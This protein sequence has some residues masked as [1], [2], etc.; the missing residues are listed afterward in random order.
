M[1]SKLS[2]MFGVFAIGMSVAAYAAEETYRGATVGYT[3]EGHPYIGN[4]DASVT[5]SEFSDYLCPFCERH[6]RQTLPELIEKYAVP[7]KVRFVF[8]D[9]PIPSLHPQAPAAAE[10]ALCVGEQ[11]AGLFW[12]MHDKIF[13]SRGRWAT[14]ESPASLL[15]ELAEAV[16]ADMTAYLE[17]VESG[18]M[19]ERV[20]ASVA[21]GEALGFNAT[22][23]FHFSGVDGQSYTLS[24]AHPVQKFSD[25]LDALLEGKE[26]PTP[27][28]PELPFWANEEGLKPNPDRP[29]FTIAGDPYKGNPKA[30]V[31]V[32][33]FS[34]FQC[35]SCQRHALEAQ[36][37]IDEQF[38]DTGKV[39]WVFKNLPLAMHANAPAAAA[40]AECAGDQGKFWDL[41][42]LLFE[43]AEEWTDADPDSTIPPIAR[44]AGLNI[45]RFRDCFNSRRSIERILGD[46]FD[47]HTV[48]SSTPTF[49]VVH[50]GRAGVLR[51]ARDAEQ[52]VE[53]LE[54][55]LQK[56]PQKP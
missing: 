12:A 33:E 46:I 42:R 15:Q 50:D 21:A 17:C 4:A 8:R 53:F 6:Y 5:M 51:G 3:E 13:E 35:A 47:A 44:E 27:P 32:I 23:S 14:A 7:G 29:G 16:D 49:V 22:P 19:R 25:W 55:V 18:R 20:D 41:H 26:P 43:R 39:L 10:A 2:A 36:P 34:D 9:F 31:A 30:P 48:S 37:V 11:G 24:G 28:P 56:N 54:S 1:R 40:A 52:F 45:P 38:I